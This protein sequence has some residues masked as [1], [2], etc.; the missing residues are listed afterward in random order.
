MRGPELRGEVSITSPCLLRASHIKPWKSCADNHERL[1]GNNGLLLAPHVDHL[2][3]RGFL[4]FADDGAVLL[5]PRVDKS[6]FHRLGIRPGMN[7]GRFF[8]RQRDYLAY[9]RD[10]VFL[11]P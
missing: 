3:D 5:S 7:V 1:D 4:T 9:H 2:F 8:A 6:E 11:G 10:F